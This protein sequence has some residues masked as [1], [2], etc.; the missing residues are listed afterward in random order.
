[1]DAAAAADD[2]FFIQEAH[3]LTNNF[4]SK[5]KSIQIV[6]LLA[7]KHNERIGNKFHQLSE[8][9]P[10]TPMYQTRR[11]LRLQQSLVQVQQQREHQEPPPLPEPHQQELQIDTMMPRLLIERL[12]FLCK[13]CLNANHGSDINLAKSAVETLV[14][15]SK[16]GCCFLEKYMVML[17]NF[18]TINYSLS[19]MNGRSNKKKNT[20]ENNVDEL[21]KSILTVDFDMHQLTECLRRP[22]YKLSSVNHII[23][24]LRHVQDM[25]D[26]RD[27]KAINWVSAL[28][29]AYFVELA[30]SD[31][32]IDIIEDIE[33]WIDS[34]CALLREIESTK[35][36]IRPILELMDTNKLE[37]T[38][39]SD[40]LK[41][42]SCHSIEGIDLYPK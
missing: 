30:T 20:L 18:C 39:T 29:D 41:L 21:L 42:T 37:V 6:E 26:Y 27:K 10:L 22:D 16:V 15:A 33:T 23:R 12:E 5:D 38:C 25:L 13:A 28:I 9:Q 1:M 3:K 2:S 4:Y 35:S 11:S 19:K 34:E 24:I 31:E 36:L 8:V 17:I 40:D 14:N 32:G 7:K